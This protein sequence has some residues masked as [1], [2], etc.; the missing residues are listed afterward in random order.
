MKALNSTCILSC[1]IFI[2]FTQKRNTSA[3]DHY[4]IEEGYLLFIT[5]VIIWLPW[6][7]RWQ[8]V[9]ES[10]NWTNLFVFLVINGF[11]DTSRWN[12]HLPWRLKI[13]QIMP[14]QIVLTLWMSYLLLLRRREQ[15]LL[16]L[17]FHQ[18]ASLCCDRGHIS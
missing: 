18:W 4:S 16:L 17:I 2:I 12:L 11:N 5:V 13:K 7:E 9:D 3:L 14:L 6:T 1:C 8:S 10:T 15:L